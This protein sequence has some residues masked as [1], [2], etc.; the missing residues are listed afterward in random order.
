MAEALMT[1]RLS[2]IAVEGLLGAGSTAGETHSSEQIDF[3][4]RRITVDGSTIVGAMLARIFYAF[5]Q[6]EF[7]RRAICVRTLQTRATKGCKR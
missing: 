6:R 3:K 2:G 4:R 7:G 5:L 1:L